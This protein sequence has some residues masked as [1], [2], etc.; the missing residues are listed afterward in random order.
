MNIISSI[1]LLEK[2]TCI[3]ATF[4]LESVPIV[5]VN[6]EFI[7]VYSTNFVG[8]KIVLFKWTVQNFLRCAIIEATFIQYYWI[9]R[10][11]TFQSQTIQGWFLIYF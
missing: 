9:H 3:W 2:E 5:A 11:K 8:F 10:H 6:L 4:C 7:S 1:A